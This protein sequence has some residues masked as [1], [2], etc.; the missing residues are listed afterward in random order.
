MGQMWKNILKST[1]MEGKEMDSQTLYEIWDALKANK[2][3]NGY[4]GVIRKRD[5]ED[6][7]PVMAGALALAAIV[8]AVAIMVVL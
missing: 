7:H 6:R 4:C 3:H 8:L 5:F 1:E 2:K